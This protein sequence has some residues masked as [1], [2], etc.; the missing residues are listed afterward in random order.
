MVSRR[1]PPTV[2]ADRI[3]LGPD[4]DAASQREVGRRNEPAAGGDGSQTS[5][6]ERIARRAYEIS[7]SRGGEHGRA[8]EDWLQAE[9]EIDGE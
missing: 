8:L 2:D 1:R 5:R 6:I 9:R 4:G 3:N 7:Q